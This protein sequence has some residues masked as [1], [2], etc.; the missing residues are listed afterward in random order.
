VKWLATTT[1]APAKALPALIVQLEKGTEDEKE[2][3]AM[4]RRQN[5]L[6][7]RK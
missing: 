4:L 5:T 1:K 2:F 7:L 6:N 3:A